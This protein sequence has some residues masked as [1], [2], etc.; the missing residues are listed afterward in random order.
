MRPDALAVMLLDSAP[1][2]MGVSGL[3]GS[4]KSTVAAA[5]VRLA[6][7]R[8]VQAVSLS[9]DDFYLGHDARQ[10]LGREVHPLLA[11]RGVPG[12]HDLHLLLST[13]DALVDPATHWP[14]AVPRFDKGRDDRAP[15][16]HWQYVDGPPSLV[17]FEGWCLGV[18][19]QDDTELGLPVNALERDEDAD[20]TWRR[21]VN[22]QL[23]AYAAAWARIDGLAVLQA[24]DWDVVRAW[25]G[26]AE[27]EHAGL[28]RAMNDA[29]LDRF[30]S[31]YE[32]ISRHALRTLPARADVLVELDATRTPV[33]ITRR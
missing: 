22:A 26:Q 7:L 20:G 33:R 5:M 21:F 14:L 24:P 4:G 27:H 25:R 12:T 8:G 6:G 23:G 19:P 10:A 17:V 28:P 1:R 2:L 32:R 18:P 30:V 16:E 13:L 31:H 11:T 3:Q 9:L 15:R 29:A